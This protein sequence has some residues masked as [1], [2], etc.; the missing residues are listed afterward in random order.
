MPDISRVNLPA[1]TTDLAAVAP[2]PLLR[3]LGVFIIET[4]GSTATVSVQ[5]SAANDVTK[6][7]LSVSLAANESKYIALG[8]PGVGVPCP[9]GIWVERVTGTTRLTVYYR[10][11][12][13]ARDGR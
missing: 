8:D 12:D 1:A 4:A 11:F 5:E 7:L 2:T 9:A 6:E 3:L 10:T 13:F